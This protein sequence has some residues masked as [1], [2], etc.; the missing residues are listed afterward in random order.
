MQKLYCE[1]CQSRKMVENGKENG[2]T[3]YACRV[4]TESGFRYDDFYLSPKEVGYYLVDVT[5]RRYDFN[6][7]KRWVPV[8]R[9]GDYLGLVLSAGQDSTQ[10]SE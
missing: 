8:A 3:I 5:V 9:L 6:G 1:S 4:R 2:R 7:R 10:L